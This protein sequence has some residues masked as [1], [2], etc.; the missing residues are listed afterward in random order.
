MKLVVEVSLEGCLKTILEIAKKRLAAFDELK[1]N[2]VSTDIVI[3]LIRKGAVLTMKQEY[4]LTAGTVVNLM[5]MPIEDLVNNRCDYYEKVVEHL[6]EIVEPT[7]N[8]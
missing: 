4:G 5:D 2:N 6:R 3:M 8:Q 7:C 1:A